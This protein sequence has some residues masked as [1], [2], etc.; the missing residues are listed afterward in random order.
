MQKPVH[1]SFFFWFWPVVFVLLGVP[2]LDGYFHE[3]NLRIPRGAGKVPAYL[4]VSDGVI[5][6]DL[7]QTPDPTVEKS[8][9]FRRSAIK[10]RRF[11]LMPSF[12]EKE[13]FYKYQGRTPA[14]RKA[15]QA[16]GIRSPL[17]R[18]KFA[19]PIWMLMTVVGGMWGIAVMRRSRRMVREAMA[20]Q[21]KTVEA[22]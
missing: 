13:D 6:L 19:V 14:E 2:M 1:H 21:A 5:H 12:Y 16:A 8:F 11:L 20:M 15:A 17:L 7:E 3:T 22:G 4:Y 18:Y 9:A 10:D